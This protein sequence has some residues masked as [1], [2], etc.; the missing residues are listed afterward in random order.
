VAKGGIS[1][2]WEVRY[3]DQLAVSHYMRC[4]IAQDGGTIA[5]TCDD[6]SRG[7]STVSGSVADSRV[8]LQAGGTTYTGTLSEAGTVLNGTLPYNGVVLRFEGTKVP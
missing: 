8:V 4:D 5:G 1:G 2:V 3:K 7:R 6:P